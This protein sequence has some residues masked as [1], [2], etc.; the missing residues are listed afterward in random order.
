MRTAINPTPRY[1]SIIWHVE[2][3][4]WFGHVMH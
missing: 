1:D 2:H 4:A 3:R